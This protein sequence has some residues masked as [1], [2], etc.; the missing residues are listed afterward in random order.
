MIEDIAV[1]VGQTQRSNRSRK[2]TSKPSSA[3]TVTALISGEVQTDILDLAASSSSVFFGKEAC[4][5]LLHKEKKVVS[6]QIL[7]FLEYHWA[8]DILLF[9]HTLPSRGLW[10]LQRPQIARGSNK[11]NSTR[12]ID[13]PKSLG[14]VLPILATPTS[15]RLAGFHQLVDAFS[16]PWGNVGANKAMTSLPS[17]DGVVN[18]SKGAWIADC[19][20]GSFADG[21]VLAIDTPNAYLTHLNLQQEEPRNDEK[22]VSS[23]HKKH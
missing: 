20:F 6:D 7:V 11:A 17:L 22:V 23:H 18:V 9:H 10:L 19:S 16:N 2:V 4:L 8:S 1:R 14:G 13:H 15:S 5:H 12:C 3:V 21:Q